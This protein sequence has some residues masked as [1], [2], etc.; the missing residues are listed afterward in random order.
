MYNNDFHVYASKMDCRE[1]LVS[2]YARGTGFEKTKT[3]MCKNVVFVTAVCTK[4]KKLY[5][6]ATEIVPLPLLFLLKL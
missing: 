3:E 1:A 5:V 2:R 4:G 6:Q